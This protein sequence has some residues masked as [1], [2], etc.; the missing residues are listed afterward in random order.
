MPDNLNETV[1]TAMGW[2]F[3]ATVV[4]CYLI[5]RYY[6]HVKPRRERF[7]AEWQRRF[8][9]NRQ[10]VPEHRQWTEDDEQQVVDAEYVRLMQR[11]PDDH[12]PSDWRC[13][14]DKAGARRR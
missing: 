10:W 3:V 2:F 6:E 4:G 9:P 11:P 8:E 1:V 14:G 13:W 12:M 5:W 7:D